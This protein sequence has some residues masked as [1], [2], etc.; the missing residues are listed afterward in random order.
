MDVIRIKTSSDI[1]AMQQAVADAAGESGLGAAQV[2]DI[3]LA[4][5]ELGR[6]AIAHAGG[7]SVE[8]E[9]TSRGVQLCFRDDGPGIADLEKA[10][11]GGHSTIGTLGRGLSGSRRLVD[12]FA[13]ST[14]RM[15]TCIR[16]MKLTMPT[17][18]RRRAPV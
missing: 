8:I 9:A 7:G 11:Q 14:G 12:E 2:L 18:G 13:L 16:V 6:N 3:V 15:G 1:I 10:L 17:S 4:A 5:T